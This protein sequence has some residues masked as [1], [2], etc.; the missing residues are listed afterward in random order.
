M[1]YTAL[2]LLNHSFLKEPLEKYSPQYNIDNN[3]DRDKSLDQEVAELKLLSQSNPRGPS[4]VQSE[5]E[6][7][8]CVGKG[9]YGEV[10]KVYI[11]Y[12]L[13]CF[14]FIEYFVP[15]VYLSSFTISLP[16]D[17]F[18]VNYTIAYISMPVTNFT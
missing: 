8:H 12:H 7:L 15:F 9:A 13:L 6:L 3:E 18:P 16:I 11:F 17:I 10:F 4:R 2:Q 5:F 1:R 14:I